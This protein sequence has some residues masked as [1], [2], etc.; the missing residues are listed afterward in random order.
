MCWTCLASHKITFH[1][2]L[3]TN[4]T[5]HHITHTHI[6][7]TKL[8]LGTCYLLWGE[9]HL[10]FHLHVTRQGSWVWKQN[11]LH[12]CCRKLWKRAWQT[13]R[14]GCWKEILKKWKY[15]QFCWVQHT[16]VTVRLRERSTVGLESW[17]ILPNMWKHLSKISTDRQSN[18]CISRSI[19]P[20]V[21]PSIRPLIGCTLKQSL[22]SNVTLDGELQTLWRFSKFL[23]TEK[24]Q[25]LFA[26]CCCSQLVQRS[27]SGLVK[28]NHLCRL[29]CS[30]SNKESY[31]LPYHYHFL[32]F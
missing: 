32:L 6:Q 8:Q 16:P 15:F 22:S 25:E 31:C 3:A 24:F 1:F 30:S 26:F 18:F 11:L 29:S 12:E 14:S 17:A 13:K 5:L 27:S 20:S 21:H 9:Q 28:E 2:L 10:H 7:N 23:T 19:Q 4:S